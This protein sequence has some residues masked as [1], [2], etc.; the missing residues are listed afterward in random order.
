MGG[1]ICECI[2]CG[3][4]HKPLGIPPWA[5]S[6]A[7]LAHLSRSFNTDY[8]T[9]QDQRINEWLKHLIVQQ[10]TTDVED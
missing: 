8:R 2:Q 6:Q 5:L 1:P 9:A 10:K 3:R 7:D 4:L